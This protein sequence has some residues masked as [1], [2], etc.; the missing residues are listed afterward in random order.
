MHA[1]AWPAT[2]ELLNLYRAAT[3]AAD[4]EMGTGGI[5]APGLVLPVVCAGHEC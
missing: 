1:S 3:H 2:A 4:M 5:S